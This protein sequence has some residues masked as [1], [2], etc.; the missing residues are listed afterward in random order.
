MIVD[1]GNLD[2]SPVADRVLAE[3]G[4]PEAGEMFKP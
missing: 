3:R 2:I 4:G 1:A